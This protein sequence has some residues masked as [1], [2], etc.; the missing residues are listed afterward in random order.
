MGLY[1]R[2]ALIGVALAA[3]LGVG[4]VEPGAQELTGESRLSVETLP[5]GLQITTVNT[6]FLV[7]GGYIPG[8]AVDQRLVLRQ[9]VETMQVVDEKGARST[10]VTVEAW[11]LDGPL[12]GTP[13]WTV[14]APGDGAD[15][16][17]S[18]F[19]VIMGENTDWFY[20]PMTAY[21][22]ADG[23]KVFSA[24]IPWASF[25]LSTPDPGSRHAAYATA[26]TEEVATD[27]ASYPNAVGLLTY[28]TAEWV[29]DRVVIEADAV[30]LGYALRA[31]EETPIVSWLDGEGMALPDIAL[32]DPEG[33]SGLTLT[34]DYPFSGLTIAIPVVD[35]RLAIAEAT[36]PEHL[37]LVA[38]TAP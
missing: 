3:V 10:A 13:L 22:L 24:S 21:R 36:V 34:V 31:V 27:L 35:D 38:L 1:R 14:T 11:R 5:E 26:Q 2:L 9:R 16:S 25:Q 23:R 33:R 17:G 7:A 32:A 12:D 29:L 30:D 8:L 28:A 15:V 6:T 19:Y 18:E 37:R 4:P 20:P